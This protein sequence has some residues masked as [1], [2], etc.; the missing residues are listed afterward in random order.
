METFCLYRTL[1]LFLSTHNQI[2]IQPK[3]PFSFQ[4]QKKTFFPLWAGDGG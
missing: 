2:S 1:S 4:A 3:I